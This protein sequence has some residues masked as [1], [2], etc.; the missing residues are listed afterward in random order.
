MGKRLFRD[1]QIVR[2]RNDARTLRVIAAEFG[3]TAVAIFKI[4]RGVT[5]KHVSFPPAVT[6]SVSAENASISA[7][8]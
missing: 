6:V 2:I 4:K 5:Y 3:V 7:D 8:F 1:E